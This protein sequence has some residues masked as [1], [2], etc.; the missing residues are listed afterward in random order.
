[1]N[2]ATKPPEAA[3]TCSGHVQALV[4]LE[5][6]ERLGDV[7]DRLVAAV[8]GRTQDR[9]H[10][11]R[12][13]VAL[14]DG[15]LG[16]QVIALALH[17]HQARLHVPVAAELLPAHLHVGAHH[18]VGAVGGLAGG[19]HPVAPAPLQRH[20][21]EHRRLARAGRRA[22]GGVMLIRTAPEARDDAH[23]TGLDLRRLGI[24]VLV[25]HVLVGGLGHQTSGDRRHPGGDERRQVQARLTVQQQLGRDRL[26]GD[27]GADAVLGHLLRGDLELQVADVDGHGERVRSSVGAGVLRA[28]RHRVLLGGEVTRGSPR[29]RQP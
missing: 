20:P 18:H 28:E 23:A 11:D 7:R 8:E 16:A 22:S 3:S 25:D 24:F 13:L 19:S 10:A 26:V 2:G 27:V 17:R 4:A 14:R 15:L 5:R 6:V 1:M 9:D 12:V 21:G 29:R